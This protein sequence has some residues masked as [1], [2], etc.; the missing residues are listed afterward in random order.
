MKF[1]IKSIFA[2]GFTFPEVLM[3]IG[4]GSIVFVAVASLSLYTGRSFAALGNYAELDNNSR[5]A[6]DVLTRDIRQVNFV[7]NFT[8]NSLVFEDSDKKTLMFIYDKDKKIFY[9]VK[10]GVTNILLTGCDELVFRTY[11]RNPIPGS[12]DLVPTTNA[13]HCKAIDVSWVCSRKI[14]NGL[15]NTESI[16]TARIVI[17][18]QQD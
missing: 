15:I 12:Y 5:N 13:V 1:K 9:R 14:L 7:D 3:T 6:L 16:Q 11:Q 17:R 10:E 2:Y 4:V 8:S 18:K